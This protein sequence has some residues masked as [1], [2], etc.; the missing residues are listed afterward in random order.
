MYWT[1]SVRVTCASEALTPKNGDKTMKFSEGSVDGS[2]DPSFSYTSQDC[3][4][5]SE[6]LGFTFEHILKN[7]TGHRFTKLADDFT[8][9]AL[10]MI[11]FIKEARKGILEG[12]HENNSL[13]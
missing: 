4:H 9:E 10:L 6:L 5:F 13:L 2:L 7:F 1:H 3:Y 8:L 12:V 11:I